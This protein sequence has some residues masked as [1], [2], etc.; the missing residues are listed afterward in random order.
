MMANM[1][2]LDRADRAI[3]R[4]L[5]ADGRMPVS[6]LSERVGLSPNATATRLRRLLAEGTISGVHARVAPEA[7]GLTLLAFVEVKLERTDGDVFAA[8]ARAAL[9]ADAIEECHMVAGGFDYLLRTRHRDMAA[10]RR[11]LSDVL[12]TLPGVRETHTYT[13]MEAVKE[14]GPLDLTPPPVQKGR[15]AGS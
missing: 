2:T 11:F 9:A 5:Q 6:L 4:L 3:L 8:F 1:T 10:Y 15:G 14:A 12:L 7:V 13:V